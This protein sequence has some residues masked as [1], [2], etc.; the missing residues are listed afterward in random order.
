MREVILRG[1]LDVMV[2]NKR[3]WVMV[4]EGL[5]RFLVVSIYENI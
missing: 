3:C 5:T 2:F 4:A 1:Q